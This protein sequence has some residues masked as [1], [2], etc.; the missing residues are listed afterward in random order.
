MVRPKS[1]SK[2]VPGAEPSAQ[3]FAVAEAAL[4]QDCQRLG[5]GVVD[6]Q[7][8]SQLIGGK[9]YWFVTARAIPAPKSDPNP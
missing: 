8:Q 7:R 3:D 5:L 1:L 4:R 2:V 6:I 9:P